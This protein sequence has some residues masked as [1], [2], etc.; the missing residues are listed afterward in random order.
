[1][2]GK[3]DYQIS[4]SVNEGIVEV[5]I[6]GEV[7]KGNISRLH[8][9]VISILKDKN[10]RAIL[11]DVSKL[12]GVPDN[13]ADAYYRVRDIPLEIR[14]LPSAVFSTTTSPAY[15]S[16]YETTAANAGQLVKWF[17]DIEEA[18]TWLKGKIKNQETGS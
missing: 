15:I 12:E 7:S 5:V 17:A 1:M 18:R 6:K 8:H 10:A 2:E 11:S 14:R 3:T 4:Y 13:I 16:F 9:E